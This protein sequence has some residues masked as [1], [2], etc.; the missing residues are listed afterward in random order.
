MQ[1]MELVD[2]YRDASVARADVLSAIDAGIVSSS[3]MPK[4]QAALVGF[5]ATVS[6]SRQ[7][8][9][10]AVAA[11]VAERDRLLD[12]YAAL[13]RLAEGLVP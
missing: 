6:E 11:L 13:R 12:T 4:A 2:R 1:I 5:E 8:V 3:A 10:G 9:E 7:A